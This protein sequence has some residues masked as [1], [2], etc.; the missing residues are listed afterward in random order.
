MEEIIMILTTEQKDLIRQV[1]DNKEMFEEILR[2]ETEKATGCNSGNFVKSQDVRIGESVSFA[3]LTWSK[4]KYND[5]KSHSYFLADSPYCTMAFGDTNH[6]FYSQIREKLNR[7]L[8]EL[9]KNDLGEH[10]LVEITTELFSLD[11]LRDYGYCK[12]EVSLLTLDAY[13]YN[14]NTIKSIE[15]WYWLATPNSTP[16]GDGSDHVL[17]V[18]TTGDVGYNWCKGGHAVRPFCIIKPDVRLVR[19]IK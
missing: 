7:D 1:L 5:W 18:Y 13:R 3:G 11:G 15:N 9:I 2:K 19:N 16:S 6:W 17:G 12:N 4:F 8:A 10:S 14:R